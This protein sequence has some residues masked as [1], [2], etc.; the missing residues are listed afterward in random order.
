VNKQIRNF[1]VGCWLRTVPR[2]ARYH[3]P[4]CNAKQ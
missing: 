1:G 2:S 3:C 4:A